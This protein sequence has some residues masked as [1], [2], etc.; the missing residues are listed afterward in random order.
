MKEEYVNEYD[1]WKEKVYIT[2]N[3]TSLFITLDNYITFM[4]P[5]A[6]FINNVL[7]SDK[8]FDDYNGDHY[9][10]KINFHL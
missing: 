5:Q 8:R 3:D 4:T 9:Q 2:N 7:F 1:N 10:T 6:I